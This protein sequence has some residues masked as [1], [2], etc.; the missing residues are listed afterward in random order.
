M[1]TLEY[2]DIQ[3]LFKIRFNVLYQRFIFEMLIGVKMF[4]IDIPPKIYETFH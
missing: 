1:G 3:S 4:D 2:S